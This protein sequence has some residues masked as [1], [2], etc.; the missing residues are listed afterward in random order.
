MERNVGEMDRLARIALGAVAVLLAT[1]Y[2]GTCGSY[3]LAGV[4]TRK[5]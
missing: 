2:T 1:G 4:T 5:R 3:S